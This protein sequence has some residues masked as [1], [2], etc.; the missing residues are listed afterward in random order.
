MDRPQLRQ[1]HRPEALGPERGHGP[2]PTGDPDMPT[3]VHPG[4]LEPQAATAC[5]ELAEEGA[6]PRAG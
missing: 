3:M 1:G 5:L 2:P 6:S 4:G